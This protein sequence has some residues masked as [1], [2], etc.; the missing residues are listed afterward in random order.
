MKQR[1]NSYELIHSSESFEV[2]YNGNTYIA[3]VE[4]DVN[5]SP[6]LTVYDEKDNRI[7]DEEIIVPVKKLI[8]A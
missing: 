8:G 5:T 2:Q 7:T 1:K 6:D 4:M 3:V